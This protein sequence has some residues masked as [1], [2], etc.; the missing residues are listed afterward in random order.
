MHESGE[1]EAAFPLARHFSTT[2]WF[3]SQIK[4]KSSYR[5]QQHGPYKRHKGSE[6]VNSFARFIFVKFIAKP[7]EKIMYITGAY[8]SFDLKWNVFMTKIEINERLT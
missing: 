2:L 8:F 4:K 5:P 3:E 1:G 7:M 6:N